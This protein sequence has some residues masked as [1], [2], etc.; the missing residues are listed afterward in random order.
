MKSGTHEQVDQ[1]MSL[2]Q[3]PLYQRLQQIFSH[4]NKFIAA[5]DYHYKSSWKRRGGTG[6]Y[7]TVV[8]PMDRFHTIV[9]ETK[10]SGAK[11][12]IFQIIRDEQN[13]G[14]T[15][16]NDGTLQACIRDIFCYMALIMAEA[17]SWKQVDSYQT[18]FHSGI[19]NKEYPIHKRAAASPGCSI[20]GTINSPPKEEQAGRSKTRLERLRELICHRESRLSALTLTQ[21]DAHI[22]II[23][24]ILLMS[25]V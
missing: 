18:A 19:S 7:F 24:E 9:E 12:D 10:L 23:L 25:E 1:Q 15:A 3:T 22:G 2:E 13:R 5:R 11:F 8:R 20:S 17:E 21:L 6:A 4:Y 14:L 16:D